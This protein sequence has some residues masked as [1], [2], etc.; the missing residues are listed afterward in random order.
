MPFANRRRQL[1]LLLN[2]VTDRELS[3]RDREIAAEEISERFDPKRHA[4]LFADSLSRDDLTDPARE[5]LIEILALMA[6]E[7]SLV[8]LEAFVLATSRSIQLRNEAR[9]RLVAL[10]RIKLRFKA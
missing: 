9:L 2:A 1:V 4:K 7:D 6:D 8:A 10:G 5:I 3:F